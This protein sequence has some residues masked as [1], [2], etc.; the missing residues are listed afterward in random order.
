MPVLDPDAGPD[1]VEGEDGDAEEPRRLRTPEEPT[2]RERED[3]RLSG[4]AQYR[5]W[6]RHCVRG[7]GRAWGHS[8]H[9]GDDAVPVISFDYAFLDSHDQ[10]EVGSDNV[11]SEGSS[12][13]LVMWNRHA[14]GLWAYL[15]PAKGISFVAVDLVVQ[16]VADDLPGWDIEE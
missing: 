2:D 12:P 4:H 13:T 16:T 7:R 14:K 15:I 9:L 11:P 6:C 8:Q 3:H 5:S 10:A 1:V